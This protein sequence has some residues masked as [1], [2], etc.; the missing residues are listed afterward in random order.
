MDLSNHLSKEVILI[1]PPVRNKW[2]LLDLMVRSIQK[3]PFCRDYGEA[4]LEEML[5]GVLERE[6]ERSTG[7]GRGFALP[8]ARLK[9]LPDFLLAL[10]ICRE[11]LEFD[12]V[13]GKPVRLACMVITPEENPTI[14]LKIMATLIHFLAEP[15]AEAGL[16]KAKRPE[17]ILAQLR[18]RKLAFSQSITAKDI[19]R[20]P[21]MNI[22]PETPLRVV[23]RMMSQHQVEAVAVIGEQGEVVGEITC[24]GLFASGIPDFLHQLSSVSFIKHFDPFEKYFS[25]DVGAVA[26]DVMSPHFCAMGEDATL[27]EIVFALSVLKYAKIHVVREGKRVGTID[28]ISVLDK[29]LNL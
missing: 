26:K 18:G 2:E 1:D 17:E 4:L 25:E 8:H 3:G 21:Y 9:N 29:I 6:K 13:D 22:R 12:S 14:A 24:D 28:R 15:E 11:G 27:I 19:M 7:I 20:K 5:P 23:T 16:M 10:A